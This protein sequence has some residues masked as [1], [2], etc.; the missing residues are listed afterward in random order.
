MICWGFALGTNSR[1][2]IGL[3]GLNTSQSQS[4]TSRTGRDFN[5]SVWA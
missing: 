1:E 2:K 3:S 5:L 4:N